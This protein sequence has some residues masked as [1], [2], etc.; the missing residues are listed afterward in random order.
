MEAIAARCCFMWDLGILDGKKKNA[1]A[2]AAAV[3]DNVSRVQTM[4]MHDTYQ[5]TVEACQTIIPE[6]INRGYKL[7]TLD[8]LAAAKGV[9]LQNGVT[10]YGFSDADI[11][12]GHISDE[13]E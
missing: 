11:E 9:E 13:G 6:L 8:T 2:H 1:Q 5:A 12:A 10:Y 4:L 7:V 3:V